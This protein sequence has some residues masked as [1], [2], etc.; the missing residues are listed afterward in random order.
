M[1]HIFEKSKDACDGLEGKKGMVNCHN[2][3]LILETK[4][5]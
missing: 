4:I 1:S 3:I 2:R 5:F